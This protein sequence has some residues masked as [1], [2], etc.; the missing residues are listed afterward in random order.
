MRNL[1]AL[2]IMAFALIAH[3]AA[4]NATTTAINTTGADFIIVAV[5]SYSTTPVTNSDSAS[6]TWSQL[7]EVQAVSANAHLRMFYVQAPTTSASHTFS[8]NANFYAIAVAAFSG[9]QAT[10]FDVQSTASA[11]SLTIQ[12]GSI[13]PAGNG[14][15]IISSVGM[16]A[17]G[18]SGQTWSVDS[19]MTISDQIA[20][21]G[22]AHNGLALAYLLSSTGAINPTWTASGGGSPNQ[23]AAIAAFKG[24]GGGGGGGSMMVMF[25]RILDGL[26]GGR[27]HGNRLQ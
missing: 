12:P 10:P 22:G 2:L 23:A 3:T 19:S 16:S 21:T 11:T 8:T 25:R 14:E 1:R 17:D 4:A 26:G 7:T 15:L 5:C 9:S 6:N 13:T 27:Q 20:P 18:A 24:S